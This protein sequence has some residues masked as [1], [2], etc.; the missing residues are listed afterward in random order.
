VQKNLTLKNAPTRPRAALKEH[1]R[2]PVLPHV[3]KGTDPLGAVPCST[4]GITV[5]LQCSLKPA[6]GRA[7]A[8][9]KVRFFPR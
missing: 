9:F 6:H 5:L 4:S 8:F 3:L 1:F 2:K 7:G